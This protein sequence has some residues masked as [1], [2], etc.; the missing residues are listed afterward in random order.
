MRNAA[1]VAEIRSLRGKL[2]Q[3]EIA[4]R[5]G[6]SKSCVGGIIYRKT[7]KHVP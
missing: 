3:A 2:S 5:F 1:A 4:R 6:V 7:W